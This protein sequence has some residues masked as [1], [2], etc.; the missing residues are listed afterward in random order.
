MLDLL[1]LM[2]HI[3]TY[4]V[5]ISDFGQFTLP[6]T[7]DSC[8]SHNPGDYKSLLWLKVISWSKWNIVI[9]RWSYFGCG[10]TF[11]KCGETAIWWEINFQLENNFQ[12]HFNLFYN[13]VNGIN[14][15]NWMGY[16]NNINEK[17]NSIN[18]ARCFD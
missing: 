1:T 7:C 16:S 18:T 4:C 13:V 8:K 10:C 12:L 11:E 14:G 9:T 15:G 3:H 17:F 5:Q 2:R 6:T